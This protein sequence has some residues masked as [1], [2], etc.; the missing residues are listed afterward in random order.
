MIII[1]NLLFLFCADDLA[2]LTNIQRC[3]NKEYD[4]F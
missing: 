3:Q 4:F 1:T 2:V